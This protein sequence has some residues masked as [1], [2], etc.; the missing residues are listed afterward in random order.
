MLL[1]IDISTVAIGLSV[2]DGEDKVVPSIILTDTLRFSSNVPLEE[3]AWLFRGKLKEIKSKFSKI[4]N[5]F[6]EEPFI[7]GGKNAKTVAILNRFNG[8]CCYI[9]YDVFNKKP[10]MINPISARHKLGIKV[11]KLVKPKVKKKVIIDFI[12]ALYKDTN[13]PFTYGL[14]PKGNPAVGTDDRADAIV[15]CLS[16]LKVD[17]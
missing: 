10:T 7:A 6:V 12:E 16:T 13:T 17:K 5:V 9:V 8:M 11:P 15:L 2:L 4:E 3:K 1:G 14:T